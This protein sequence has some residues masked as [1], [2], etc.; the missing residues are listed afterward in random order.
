MKLFYRTIGTGEPLV[1][2]HGLFGSSDNWQT[3][4]KTISDRYCVI[5]IDLRNHGLSPHDESFNYSTIGDD[6]LETMQDMNLK[7]FY[8]MGHSLGGKAAG[9]F[10][11][12]HSDLIRKLVIIDIAPKSYPPH[13]Q[14]YFKVMR[15]MDFDQITN[16]I[17]ADEYMQKEI[18]EYPIRQF[19]L[20]NLVRDDQGRFRW[21]F[22]LEVLYQHYDEIN[23]TLT[24]ASPY[25]NPTL[26]IRGALSNY[27][28][29][30]DYP[31]IYDLF[32]NSKIETIKEAGHWVH[33]DQQEQ[34]KELLVEF[35]K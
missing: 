14:V 16:R 4:A 34:L 13:H 6:L 7:S 28:T 21:R 15:S 3:F 17:Q 35:L 11:L 33:V 26:F 2:L 32:P 23:I 18:L 25:T 1:I 9:F 5:S 29:S 22:N 12:S 8:L 20:K 30:E 10:A 19:L 24:S 27:I 31:L